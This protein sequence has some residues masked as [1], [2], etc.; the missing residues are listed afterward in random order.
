ET[1]AKAG[2]AKRSIAFLA[3]TAEESGL[4]GSRY[5]AEHPVYPLAHTVGGV[6]MD[7]LNIVGRAKDFVLV[8]A[9]KSEIED[10][11][12]PFVAAEGRVIGT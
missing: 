11:V 12:K 10:L 4:L 2:P 1:Q 5:Y 7:G 8:G 9:G 6:N 3:V